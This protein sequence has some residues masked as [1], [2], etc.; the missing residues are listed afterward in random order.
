LKADIKDGFKGL[1]RSTTPSRSSTPDPCPAEA[2]R[3]VEGISNAN[4]HPQSSSTV[5]DGLKVSLNFTQTLLKRLPEIVDGNPVKMALS[6]AKV[7][8]EIK[9]VSRLP[10]LLVRPPTH[11]IYRRR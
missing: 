10:I 3:G 11:P 8:L 6:L 1:I 5:K 7:I 4:E 2:A 9:E